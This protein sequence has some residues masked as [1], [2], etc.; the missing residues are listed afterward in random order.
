MELLLF[1]V[2][3]FEGSTNIFDDNL[4]PYLRNR[5]NISFVYSSG[6]KKIKNYLK[7]FF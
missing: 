4:K 6:L 7:K 3:K 1:R 2:S 5:K